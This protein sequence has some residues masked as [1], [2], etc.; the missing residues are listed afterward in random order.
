M[1][2]FILLKL[3]KCLLKVRRRCILM[4]FVI[5][6]ICSFVCRAL[7]GTAGKE[8][9]C[10]FPPETLRLPETNLCYRTFPDVYVLCALNYASTLWEYCIYIFEPCYV[11]HEDL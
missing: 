6:Y 9:K 4:Y 8:E 3:L 10:R 5:Q 7:H 11:I 1:Y 2:V